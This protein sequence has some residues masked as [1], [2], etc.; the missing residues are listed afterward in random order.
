MEHLCQENIFSKMFKIPLGLKLLKFHKDLSGFSGGD[1]FQIY[2]S[3][4]RLSS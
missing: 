2:V 3:S 4:V 1:D